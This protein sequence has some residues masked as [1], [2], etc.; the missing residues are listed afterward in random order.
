MY[1]PDAAHHTAELTRLFAGE[2]GHA[3]EVLD[4]YRKAYALI[5]YDLF[6]TGPH[7]GTSAGAPPCCGDAHYSRSRGTFSFQVREKTRR[8]AS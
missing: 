6:G 2:P 8:S 7:D 1:G 3:E 4:L 5:T